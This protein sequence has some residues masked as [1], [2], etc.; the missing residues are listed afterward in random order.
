MRTV[1]RWGLDSIRI[2]RMILSLS[3]TFRNSSRQLIWIKVS[4]LAS[5]INSQ[6]K[7]RTLTPLLWPITS[8]S[9]VANLLLM[10]WEFRT[11]V[12]PPAPQQAQRRISTASKHVSLRQQTPSPHFTSNLHSATTLLTN[13]ESKTHLKRFFSGLWDRVRTKTVVTS[14]MSLNTSSLSSSMPR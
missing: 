10:L 12:H 8:S 4:L 13:K 6:A 2:T 3:T 1:N 9:L 11:I 7:V 5:T 14:K